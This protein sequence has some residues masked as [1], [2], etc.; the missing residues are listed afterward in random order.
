MANNAGP[1]TEVRFETIFGARLH[2]YCA[3]RMTSSNIVSQN[4]LDTNVKDAFTVEK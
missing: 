4:P 2:T 1:W 3:S